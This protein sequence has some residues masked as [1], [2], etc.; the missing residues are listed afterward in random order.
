SLKLLIGL[1]F[2]SLIHPLSQTP[3]DSY[4]LLVTSFA[5]VFLRGFDLLWGSVWFSLAPLASALCLFCSGFVRC[6]LFCL[7]ESDVVW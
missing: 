4:L 6:L 7:T 3:S 5:P 2:F 1:R